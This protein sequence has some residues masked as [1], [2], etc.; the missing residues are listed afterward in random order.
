MHHS[1][2]F[3]C[4][5]F[6]SFTRNLDVSR[7]LAL[8]NSGIRRTVQAAPCGKGDLACGLIISVSLFFIAIREERWTVSKKKGLQK[9]FDGHGPMV[10]STVVFSHCPFLSPAD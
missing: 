6:A 3:L 9:S 5:N 2:L 7:P 8:A 1:K 10:K 4:Q